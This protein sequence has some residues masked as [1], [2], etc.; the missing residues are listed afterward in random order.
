MSVG[1]ASRTWLVSLGAA[2]RLRGKLSAMKSE[3]GR[4]EANRRYL[5]TATETETEMAGFKK[6]HLAAGTAMG[7]QREW[8]QKS[9]LPLPAELSVHSNCPACLD[10]GM[11]I[12]NGE[13]KRCQCW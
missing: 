1:D 5:R 3:R 11:L 10:V 13:A 2:M 9:T 7:H 4:V 6:L 12:V 8:E